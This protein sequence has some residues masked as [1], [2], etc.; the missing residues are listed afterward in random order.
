MRLSRLAALAVVFFAAG[1]RASV[2]E[3]FPR[4]DEL[5]PKLLAAPRQHQLGFSRYELNRRAL[6]DLSL[7]HSLGLLRGRAGDQLWLWQWD[8]RAMAFSRWS[9]EGLD[10]ADV[11]MELPVTVRRGD[12]SFTGS[13]F[14]ESSY[15]VAGQ[16]LD[17]EDRRSVAAGLRALAALEPW[18]FLRAY[19][20]ASFL[21]DTA[22]SPKRWGLQTGIELMSGDL[23]LFA[24]YPVRAYAAEDLQMP[25][26]AGYNPSSRAA[27]G[28]KL[29]MK[30]SPKALRVQAGHYSG[31]SYFGQF[32]DDHEDFL[33][34]S[35]IFEL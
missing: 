17:R 25:E 1:A 14:H 22:P 21:L 34:L 31:R 2:I 7:G 13:L 33:D 23:G 9:N 30:A 4:A 3:A 20:G 5:F 26:R 27:V 6:S 29:G 28:L 10:A 8:A 19:A 35:L 12:I 32:Q 18:P 11:L 16:R 24:G 15:L